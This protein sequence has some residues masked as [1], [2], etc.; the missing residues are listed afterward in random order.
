[1]AALEVA[2]T[3]Y[4][5]VDFLEWQRQGSLDLNPFYQRRS[6]WNP[7]VKSLLIDSLLRG[8][9]LPLVFLH[10]RLDVTTSRTVRQ[11]VDGQQRLRTILAYI[12]IDSLEN[13]DEWDRFTVLRAHNRDYAGLSFQQLPDDVQTRI[14]QTPL[15]VNVLPSDIDDVTVLTIF[16]RMNSTGLKL[17]PQ[18]IRNAT[19]FGEF[20]ETSYSL[21]YQQNQRW[22]NWGIFTRQDVAQMKEVELSADLMGFLINGISARSK[23]SIDGLYRKFD[24]GVPGREALINDFEAT[25]DI[26]EDVYGEAASRSSLRRFRTTAWFYVAFAVASGRLGVSPSAADIVRGMERTELDIRKAESDDVVMKPLR[27]A[28]ADKAS[29]RARADY[30]LARSS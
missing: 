9:P 25:F 4:S 16:Q 13:V 10:N 6:V 7:R 11:V 8:Y 20:K 26:L 2:K 1:M 3:T 24:D 17:N 22:V 27:G 23:A 30:L 5:I 12:D 28:T 18:E 15:S 19:W 29:R 21:A 14:L